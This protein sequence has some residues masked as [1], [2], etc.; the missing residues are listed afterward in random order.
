MSSPTIDGQRL[1]VKV[2]RFVTFSV[3]EWLAPDALSKPY[4]LVKNFH[5]TFLCTDQQDR[6][7]LY[8]ELREI[9]PASGLSSPRRRR[10]LAIF[11]QVRWA[12]Q[13]VGDLCRMGR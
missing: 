9:T 11:I 6:L 12:I 13:R 1:G 5:Q 4:D 8:S 7:V 2:A 10:R 3:A